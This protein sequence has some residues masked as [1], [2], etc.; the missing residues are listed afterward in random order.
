MNARL[1]DIFG[2]FEG[3]GIYTDVSTL[4]T[5][6]NAPGPSDKT[7]V[8]EL[9]V[10][11][12]SVYAAGNILIGP[13]VQPDAT[14]ALESSLRTPSSEFTIDSPFDYLDSENYKAAQQVIE[15][16]S[17]LPRSD[18]SAIYSRLSSLLDLSADEVD[19][20][21]LSASSLFYFVDFLRTYEKIGS[22]LIFM[23]ESGE[24]RS[25]WRVSERHALAVEFV[26]DGTVEFVLFAPNSR[27]PSKTVIQSGDRLA[28]QDLIP[29]LQQ[30]ADIEWLWQMHDEHSK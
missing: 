17:S 4:G 24:I 15:T 26:S 27:R 18:C 30:G 13:G 28:W 21:V 7:T 3:T 12:M 23:Q 10:P 11:E 29:T 19:Q 1:E 20:R 5:T 22:P 9:T 16:V 25:E 14:L 6:P 8:G 2:E